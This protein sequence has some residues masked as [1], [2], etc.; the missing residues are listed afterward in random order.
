MQLVDPKQKPATTEAFTSAAALV[1][2]LG[3]W[4]ARQFTAAL[5]PVGLKPRQFGTLTELRQGPLTQQ[6][7]GDAVGTDAAQLVGLLNELEADGLVH[8]RRDQNDRRRHI[9]EISGD[10]LARLTEADEALAAIETRLLTGLDEAQ[11]IQLRSLLAYVAEHGGYDEECA[12]RSDVAPC[13][14]AAEAE[15]DAC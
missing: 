12:G 11:Q 3:R 1:A 9:V 8:R 15:D 7:L 2:K 14:S 4:S 6:A 13:V 10:G 5:K